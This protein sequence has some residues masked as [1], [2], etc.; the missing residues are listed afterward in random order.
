MKQ[1]LSPVFQMAYPTRPSEQT[2]L[3][4]PYIG[5]CRSATLLFYALARLG[6]VSQYERIDKIGQGT[7]G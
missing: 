7:F 6:D 2:P 3:E 5:L 1:L 4:F